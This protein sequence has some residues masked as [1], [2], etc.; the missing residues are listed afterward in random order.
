MQGPPQETRATNRFDDDHASDIIPLGPRKYTDSLVPESGLG[1]YLENTVPVTV[2]R[3]EEAILGRRA[4]A[5]TTGGLIVDLTPFD[6]IQRGVSRRHAAIHREEDGYYITDLNSTNGTRINGRRLLP[7]TPCR[8]SSGD[9]V[10]L[11]RLNLI[12]LYK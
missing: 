8:L 11:G 12:V 9:V 4:S 10:S 6:A 7:N 2:V 1:I 5:S 3:D